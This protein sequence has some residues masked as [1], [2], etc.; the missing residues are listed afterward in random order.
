MGF[1]NDPYVVGQLIGG[2]AGA[3]AVGYFVGRTLFPAGRTAQVAR[4][5]EAAG[6]DEDD[7]KPVKK[8]GFRPPPILFALVG[9]LMG[10]IFMLGSIA[11]AGFSVGSLPELRAGLIE[12]C[13]KECSK[14]GAAAE[15]CQQACTCVQTEVE[16]QFQTDRE[17][18]A[19]YTAAS[20][21]NEAALSK[22]FSAR[23]VCVRRLKQSAQQGD[24][25]NP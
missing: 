15:V 20:K 4:L 17:R 9:G 11:K 10:F 2:A 14:E 1:F 19:W 16:A 8:P 25:P 21:R 22:L 12:G 23:T 5:M 3:G 6:V 7:G 18:A 13:V 24:E